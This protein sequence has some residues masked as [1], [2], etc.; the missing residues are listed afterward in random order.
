[1]L[2]PSDAERLALR[3][4]P[5]GVPAGYQEWRRLLFIH[6]PVPANVLRPL[7]PRILSLDQF[8]G[9]AYVSLTPFVVQ[10]ARPLGVPRNLGLAFL[11][12]NVRTYVHLE[13][14]QPGVYFFSLDASSLLAV[15]GARVSLGLPYLYARGNERRFQGHVEYSLQ[16]RSRSRPGCHVRYELGEPRA[17]AEP[18]TLDFFLIERY[19]LHVQ[20]GSR[21]WSVRVHHQP[22]PLRSVSVLE[23]EDG[24]AQADGLTE[25]Q[26][27]SLVHFSPGV[28]V[29]IYP[30]TVQ[31]SD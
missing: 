16:R 20:R 19:L 11:E 26:T 17:A 6:W 15:L 23:F 28:D 21:L 30:P 18:A 27:T 2:E 25:P 10:A 5:A 12:T 13:G 31:R 8:E 22:Y 24:L 7:V 29:A 4:R 1:M 3:R 14:G 9:V